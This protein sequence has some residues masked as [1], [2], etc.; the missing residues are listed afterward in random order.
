MT[1]HETDPTDTG[2]EP[3]VS[4]DPRRGGPT[5]DAAVANA[6]EGSQA[7]GDHVPSGREPSGDS[8]VEQMPEVVEQ[9]DAE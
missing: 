3:L 6:E 8:R 5:I 7:E 9:W 2:D 1:S 4:P